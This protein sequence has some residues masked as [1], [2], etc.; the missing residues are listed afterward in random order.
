MF[1]L[2]ILIGVGS[3]DDY[4]VEFVEIVVKI[5]IFKYKYYIML[6]EFKL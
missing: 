5:N 4:I 3:G 1:V 6:C 2:V